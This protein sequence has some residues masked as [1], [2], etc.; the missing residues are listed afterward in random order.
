MERAKALE[1]QLRLR[2]RKNH[3]RYQSPARRGLFVFGL[4]SSS[5]FKE[6]GVLRAQRCAH[7]F[8]PESKACQECFPLPKRMP[9]NEPSAKRVHGAMLVRC[10]RCR[11]EIPREKAERDARPSKDGH[12]FVC[13]APCKESYRW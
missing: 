9:K 4:Y 5:V 7:G 3:E 12:N 2:G 6:G 13:V 8:Y 11:R 10:Y 1:V